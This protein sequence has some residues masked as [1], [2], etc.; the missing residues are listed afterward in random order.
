MSSQKAVMEKIGMTFDSL[1][2]VRKFVLVSA[3]DRGAT[4]TWDGV[5]MHVPKRDFIV[6]CPNWFES[7]RDP[8]TK[9]Y[10]PGTLVVF[11]LVIKEGAG[12]RR[13]FDIVRG[14]REALGIKRLP[15]GTF[16]YTK[17]FGMAGVGVMMYGATREEIEAVR[18]AAMERFKEYELA[19]AQMRVQAHESMNNN[20]VKSN[21]APLPDS[22][23]VTLAR[24]LISELAA[25]RRRK[26]LDKF[27]LGRVQGAARDIGHGSVGTA[28]PD[29]P[30][31]HTRPIVVP[32][33]ELKANEHQKAAQR[34]PEP[35]PV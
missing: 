33:V 13:T 3:M 27:D 6:E 24:E 34:V 31:K 4:P 20:R 19:D 2:E 12:E 35:D 17:D 32:G 26:L 10:I 29:A 28:A 16:E 25:D 23:E 21:L 18:T 14:L 8:V 11:D 22:E 15:D 30:P 7:Y 1:M 9:Q 5:A